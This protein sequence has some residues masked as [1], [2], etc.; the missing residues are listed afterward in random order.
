MTQNLEIEFKNMLTTREYSELLQFFHIDQA[1]IFEQVN[2]YFDTPDFLLK[3]MGSALRI[4]QKE[5][6]W[7]MTL[8]QPCQ[9][10]LLETNQELSPSSAQRAITTSR[11]PEGEIQ[12][13]TSE[14]LNIPFSQLE[15]FGSLTTK[16][17]EIKTA[18]GLFVLDYSSYL[19][20]EDYELEYEVDDY[21]RGQALFQAFLAQHDIPKRATQNK[22]QRFYQ[23]KVS[24]TDR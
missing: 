17:A 11:L 13:I 23:R 1:A 7:E 22:I 19:N 5:E 9:D 4:R 10:G 15:Y 8:K 3:K 20:T 16:R 6:S 24:L 12:Q 14:Q 18:D 2:H 21:Q